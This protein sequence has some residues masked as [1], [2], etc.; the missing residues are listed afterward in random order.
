MIDNLAFLLSNV[1]IVLSIYF[2]LRSEK[3]EKQQNTK[4]NR[5]A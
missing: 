3:T 5:R 2:M 4:N 1:G